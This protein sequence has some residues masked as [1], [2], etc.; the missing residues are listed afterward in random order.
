MH[1]KRPEADG[2]PEFEGLQS[3]CDPG[4]SYPLRR[5]EAMSVAISIAR[6]LFQNPNKQQKI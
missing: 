6:P 4:A 3:E 2:M 1:D 5:Q